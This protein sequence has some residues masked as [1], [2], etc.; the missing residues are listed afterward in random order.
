MVCLKKVV[1]LSLVCVL[2]CACA[3]VP[4][5]PALA[6]TDFTAE[7]A[8]TL[9]GIEYAADYTR[10]AGSETLAFSAPESLCGMTA[11][12]GTDGAVTVT[13]GDLTYVAEAADGMFAFTRLFSMPRDA[14]R[15]VSETDGVR[16]FSGSDGA[17]NCTLYTDTDG[18][19]LRL[20]GTVGGR[21][22]DIQVLDFDERSDPQ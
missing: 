10:D 17:D 14:L 12:R 15:Y 5:A 13:I 21:E 18:L 19:L 7:L 6:G 11:V 9:D 20:C 2:F 1:L 8:F 22:Y 3:A 4:Q 16:C